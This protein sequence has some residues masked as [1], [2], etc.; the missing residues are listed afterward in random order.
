MSEKEARLEAE[1][2]TIL[3]RIEAD[4]RDRPPLTVEQGAR[5]VAD[6]ERL[7]AVIEELA[8]LR[9]TMKAE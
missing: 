4:A 8:A 5:L 1:G 3:G 7:S 6:A 2:R 9:A